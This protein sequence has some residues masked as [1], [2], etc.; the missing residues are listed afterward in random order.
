MCLRLVS[1]A[2]VADS[3]ECDE[4]SLEVSFSLENPSYLAAEQS[5]QAARAVLYCSVPVSS[6]SCVGVCKGRLIFNI[7]GGFHLLVVVWIHLKPYEMQ[8][9]EVM[10]P[11][12]SLMQRLEHP[13]NFNSFFRLRA[14]H[15]PPTHL[16]RILITSLL[17]AHAETT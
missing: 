13:P 16:S 5:H 17:G 15:S 10:L 7:P 8:P 4:A 1:P 12:Y 11:F 2:A 6:L 3:G 14:F 9:E